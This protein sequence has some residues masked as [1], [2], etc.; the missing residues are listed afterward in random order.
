MVQF[1]LMVGIG[2]GVPGAEADIRL[3]DVVVSQPHQGY[4]GVIQYDFGKVTPTS[5][6]PT[7]FFSIPRR[8]YCLVRLQKCERISF[9]D[10]ANFRNTSPSFTA[11]QSSHATLPDPMFFLKQ[12]TIMREDQHVTRADQTSRWI[13]RYARTK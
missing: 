13:G 6:R 4:G 5:F 11:F 12:H 10:A 1:G 3:G 9:N 2:G 7:G 8:R